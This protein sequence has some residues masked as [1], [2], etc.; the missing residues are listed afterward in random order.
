MNERNLELN[1]KR[2][3]EDE[4]KQRRISLPQQ[5]IP[6][7]NNSVN[8]INAGS[9]AFSPFLEH[10]KLR[11]QTFT[12]NNDQR[13][14]QYHY[15]S[16]NSH[17]NKFVSPVRSVSFIVNGS[18]NP[19]SSYTFPPQRLLCSSP[20]QLP[21]VPPPN[22]P[23]YLTVYSRPPVHSSTVM[24][25]PF[26]NFTGPCMPPMPVFAS[27]SSVHPILP[28]S[29]RPSIPQFSNYNPLYTPPVPSSLP[30]P[31]FFSCTNSTAL[32]QPFIPLNV[33]PSISAPFHA[34]F[35]LPPP[36]PSSVHQRDVT[37]ARPDRTV[38]QLPHRSVNSFYSSAPFNS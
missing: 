15:N 36:L 10:Y 21:N 32:R 37:V 11:T 28:P 17:V 22:A 24:P 35:V 19:Q 6:N 34:Q 2:R 23:N 12:S 31:N 16:N 29:I 25:P 5:V 13:S 1:A 30:Q 7:P 20:P 9:L 4:A 18:Y 27:Q 26:S 38:S 33:R 8:S 3:K 14:G